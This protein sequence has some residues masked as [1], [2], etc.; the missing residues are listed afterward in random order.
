[1]PR[2]A[3]CPKIDK[4]AMDL[5]RASC[6]V[7]RN[8]VGCVVRHLIIGAGLVITFWT[9]WSLGALAQAHA[10][11]F[12][13]RKPLPTPAA[14]STAPAPGR[15]LDHLTGHHR[16]HRRTPPPHVRRLRVDGTE[17][18]PAGD[19]D[20]DGAG[21]GSSGSIA[22]DPYQTATGGA[23]HRTE[24]PPPPP[25]AARRTAVAQTTTVPHRPPARHRVRE[26]CPC[27][28][29]GT[30]P[31]TAAPRRPL[32]GSITHVPER[33]V[34]RTVPATP[35]SAPVSGSGES[36]CTGGK[37]PSGANED[38]PRLSFQTPGL[39]CVTRRQ[40]TRVGRYIAGKPSFSPD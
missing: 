5:L 7:C 31:A 22:Q 21:H 37:T 14:A 24:Q 20:Q 28:T 2:A 39:W 9:F 27:G 10:D 38:V 26:P 36:G 6:A 40:T 30:A 16:V 3:I 13:L 17:V 32:T 8:S 12:P 35:V 29:P 15:T 4:G 11:A 25:P 33:R 23:G 18:P 1:V 19:G 34:T